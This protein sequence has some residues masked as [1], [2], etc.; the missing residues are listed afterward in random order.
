MPCLNTAALRLLWHVPPA[1]GPSGGVLLVKGAHLRL[2]N[3]TSE[4]M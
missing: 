2:L 4:C 3:M 1:A